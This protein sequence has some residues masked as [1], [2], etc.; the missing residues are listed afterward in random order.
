MKKLT[1]A[2]LTLALLLIGNNGFA[3]TIDIF[4]ADNSE[5]IS[6]WISALNGETTVLENFENIATGWYPELTTNIGTFTAGGSAG[7][8]ATAYAGSDGPQFS[9]RDEPWYGRGNTTED[10]S[11]Y[12][13]SGDITELR[14]ELALSVT[15][16][17]FYLQDPSDVG[18]TTT[19][20]ANGSTSESYTLGSQANNGLF[21]V[22][23]TSDTP[24]DSIYWI[25][26]NNNDGYGLD[27]LSTVAPVPEPATLLLLGTGL[28]GIAGISRRKLKK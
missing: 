5:S 13:D 17:F 15:N 2:A 16:L 19:V 9:I 22:G 4:K 12:L 21:F 20:E 10:G 27:D 8:G 7:G 25:T 18:A 28:I 14:L 23:I 26:S 3:I 6:D 11:K 1:V 24:L